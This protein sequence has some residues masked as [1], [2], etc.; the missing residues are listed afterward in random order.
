MPRTALICVVIAGWLTSAAAA[1]GGAPNPHLDASLVPG[2][3]QACH[4]GHGKSGSP[5]LPASQQELCLS[6]H[7]TAS[8]TA[9]RMARGT[10]APGIKP[11]QISRR[12]AFGHPID[13][14]AFSRSGGV[15]CASCHSPHRGMVDRRGHNKPDGRRKLSPRNPR[16]FEH[17]LCEGCHGGNNAVARGATDV[18]RRLNPGNASF[19]PVQ[20]PS[21]SSSR[22]VTPSLAGKEI[23]CTDCHGNDNRAGS[24][25]PHESS[26]KH[27]LIDPYES[28]DG[29]P[30]STSAYALCYGC[31]ER[32]SILRGESFPMHEKHVKDLRTSCATC[33]DPHG[34]VS[35]RALIRFGAEGD[36]LNAIAPSQI[37]GRLAFVSDGP[38]AGS[39][40]LT[41]HGYDHAPA[42]YG[43]GSIPRT[44][45]RAGSPSAS[46]RRPL[47]GAG[48]TRPSRGLPVPDARVPRSRDPFLPGD[49]P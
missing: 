34:S 25:G 49:R 2:G 11:S 48:G 36:R 26:V 24:A 46:P 35:N 32:D 39:C 1:P 45:S 22:S 40:Y 3:C 16:Q 20:A 14:T 18:S 43:P 4:A 6:C 17:E 33:H 30:E 42:S 15:T 31:H 19:H 21:I 13:G 5:M 44:A 9:Q 10:I 29:Q 23:N 27:V 12:Q 28:E 38:G 41:C 7:G 8:G 37:A 47:P